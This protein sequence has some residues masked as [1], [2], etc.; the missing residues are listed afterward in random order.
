MSKLTLNKANG[1]HS[2]FRRAAAVSALAVSLIVGSAT[3][4]TAGSLTVA[5]TVR[6]FQGKPVAGAP[7]PG[8]G[9]VYALVKIRNRTANVETIV[10]AT[11]TNPFWPT[12]G[13]T[14]NVVYAY[15]I[16]AGKTCTFQFGFKP[17]A[18][19][20]LY[21]GTGNVMFVSGETL[22]V[23]LIGKSHR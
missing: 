18:A 13:G 12:Y 9:C 5:P 3:A 19:G 2:V 21:T 7:C 1:G 8:K 14:C 22:T 23:T 11:A 6:H 20:T 16:P 4:A 15:A 17:T 10:S